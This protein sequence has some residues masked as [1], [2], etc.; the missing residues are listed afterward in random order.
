MLEIETSSLNLINGT[1][2]EGALKVIISSNNQCQTRAE[3]LTTIS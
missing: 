3:S 1:V 2:I